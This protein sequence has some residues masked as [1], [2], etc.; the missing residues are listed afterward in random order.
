MNTNV[1]VSESQLELVLRLQDGEQLS[2]SN[3]E[4]LARDFRALA[5][6]GLIEIDDDENG[7]RARGLTPAALVL[8]AESGLAF[9]QGD[10]P[11]KRLVRLFS[12]ITERQK[13]LD[14]IEK[15]ISRD[16]LSPERKLEFVA[17]AIRHLKFTT[18][19]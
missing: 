7:V 12:E 17:G 19:F 11:A 14:D 1:P 15:I 2:T 13:A 16:D 4:N 5:A 10:T 18:T 6:Q 8:L 3:D 9:Y